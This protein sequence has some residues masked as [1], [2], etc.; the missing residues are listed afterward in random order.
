ML[1]TGI[2]ISEQNSSAGPVSDSNKLKIDQMSLVKTLE[3]MSNNMSVRRQISDFNTARTGIGIRMKNSLVPYIVLSFCATL[4]LVALPERVAAQ[5][6]KI[7]ATHGAWQVSCG[8]PPGASREKCALVQSVTAEDRPNV[9]LTVIFLKSIDGK[10]QLLR[11]VA[12][13]GVL[14]PTGLGLKIDDKDVGHAPFL[15][16]GKVGCIA[17]VVVNEEL[18]GKLQKGGTAVFIIFQ[19]PEAGIG[20]PISLKGFTPALAALK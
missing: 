10:K 5:A 7:R 20:I 3:P 9:G 6:G 4:L 1:F 2:Q 16:C 8:K 14:L 15:K 13:L 19:T 11:V 17:E 18:V 12:P